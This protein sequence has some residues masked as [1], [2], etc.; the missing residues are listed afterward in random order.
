[1]TEIAPAVFTIPPGW[2]FVDALARGMMERAGGDP[3]AL[4]R[5]LV[6]LPTR[7][8]CRALRDAFLRLSEGRP[9]LLPRMWALGEPD[10]DEAVLQGDLELPPAMPPLRRQL[11]LARLVM[12]L[13]GGTSPEQAAQLAGELGHLLDQVRTEGLE[14]DGLEKLVPAEFAEHWQKTLD[15]LRIL[16]HHWPLIVE[17]DGCMDGSLRRLRL[18]EAQ[19]AS[20]DSHPPAQPVIAAGST[21]S[22][23]ATA[24]LLAVVARLPG[25]AVVLPGLD[26]WAD[27]DSWAAVEPG[28]PQHNLKTL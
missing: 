14:F 8:A 5:P 18:L 6:L 24:A 22:I 28:H 25:G 27:D 19:A 12:A 7:R 13:G 1:M 3:M 16:T 4:S 20:W 10:E 15:F 23:P 9:L 21:G 11:L 17:Q 26:T 2:S